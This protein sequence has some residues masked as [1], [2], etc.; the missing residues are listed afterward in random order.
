[1]PTSAVGNF[2]S[3]ENG[4]KQVLNM[5]WDD[6]E[7]KKFE[8]AKDSAEALVQALRNTTDANERALLVANHVAA[9]GKLA[10]QEARLVMTMS[11]Q[12]RTEEEHLAHLKDIK[13]SDSESD[14]DTETASSSDE[15]DKEDY[16]AR[17]RQNRLSVA[18][19]TDKADKLENQQYKLAQRVRDLEK[20]WF[21]YIYITC[22]Y[23]YT[24][25]L[26]LLVHSPS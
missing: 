21:I 5:N 12:K 26:S 16:K 9:K 23:M 14:S 7:K 11:K 24:P 1:L 8:E 19:A 13:T 25:P 15:S 3:D 22:I 17:E 6:V 20:V 18:A 10:A 4:L 2:E